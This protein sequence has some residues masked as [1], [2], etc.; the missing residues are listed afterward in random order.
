M[1][2][3]EFIPGEP[4]VTTDE[5]FDEVWLPWLHAQPIDVVENLCGLAG[6]WR[7]SQNKGADPDLIMMKWEAACSEL[8]LRK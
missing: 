6:E 7:P 8:S 2:S 5:Q 3:V 1:T 4:H